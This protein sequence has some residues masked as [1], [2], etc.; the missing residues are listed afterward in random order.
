MCAD[1][2]LTW[3]LLLVVSL[4]SNLRNLRHSQKYKFFKFNV[5]SDARNVFDIYFGQFEVFTAKNGIFDK[6]FTSAEDYSECLWRDGQKQEN[7]EEFIWKLE[8]AEQVG[9]AFVSF[10]GYKQH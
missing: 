9:G 1:H 2:T 6:T 10:V 8:L 7:H 3:L 4:N 5:E